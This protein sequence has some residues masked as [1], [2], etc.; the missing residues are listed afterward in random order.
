MTKIL[1]TGGAGFIGAHTAAALITAGREV[2]LL[3]NF[4]NSSPAALDRLA[5]VARRPVPFIEADIRD[6]LAL[7]RLFSEHAV[8]A[9]MHFAA[10]KSVK[11]SMEKPALYQAVNVD[12]T[13]TLLDAMAKAG[14]KRFV[15]SSSATVYGMAQTM[16]LTEDN[17]RAAINPYGQSKIDVEDHLMA[18]AA[19]DAEWGVAT[20]RYFNPVGAHPSGMMG[21]EPRGEPANLMPY[22]MQVAAGLRPRLKIYGDDYPTPDGTGVR[23]YIHVMDLAEGHGAALKFLENT[24]GFHAFNLGTGRGHSV[25]ELLRAFEA[26]TGQT[27]PYEIAP[28]RPG[29]AAQSWAD[30]TK[31]ERILGW[32]ARRDIAAMCADAWAFQQGLTSR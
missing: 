27:I 20:L 32:R 22:L 1:V 26:A 15:F 28:R 11:E 2:V 10:L 19:R 12:G 17:P 25:M 13:M 7:D 14:V 16:P 9:V 3:D 31:A 5:R 21:E 8:S 30:V 4:A 6:A 29:D 18:L 24:R 23:D